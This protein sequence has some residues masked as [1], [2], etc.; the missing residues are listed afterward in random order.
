M[1]QTSRNLKQ[2]YQEHIRYIRN[3]DP[4]SAFAQ[5]MLSNQHEY[6]TIEDIMKLLKPAKH[7]SMLIP[8]ESF[9][10]QAHHQHDQLI[11]EHNPDEGNPLFQLGIETTHT[12]THARASH[13]EQ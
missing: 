9:F 11:A 1:G 2:R 12:H 10:I 3:N 5:H 8:H 7:N 6:G 4:Q 13:L